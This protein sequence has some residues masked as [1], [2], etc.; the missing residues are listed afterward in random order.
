MSKT[1][2]WILD[3]VIFLI[4][5]II[6]TTFINSITNTIINTIITN[7]VHRFSFVIAII[8]IGVPKKFSSL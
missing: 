7:I 2:G 8:I 6:I 1:R 5:L 4:F 3:I